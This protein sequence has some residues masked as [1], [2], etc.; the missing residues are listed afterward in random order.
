VEKLNTPSILT[1]SRSIASLRKLHRKAKIVDASF[2]LRAEPTTTRIAWDNVRDSL[3]RGMRLRLMNCSLK[4]T[5]VTEVNTQQAF[6]NILDNDVIT[7]LIRLKVSEEIL[8]QE[9]IPVLITG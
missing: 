2:D 5:G 6:V 9:D 1:D 7:R 8:L 3:E 4:P